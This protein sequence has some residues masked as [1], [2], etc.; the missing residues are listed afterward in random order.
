M[1]LARELERK[2]QR[3]AIGRGNHMPGKTLT[4]YITL[5]PCE[6]GTEKPC[7]LHKHRED[8]RPTLSSGMEKHII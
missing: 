8:I 7:L 1:L 3:R 2:S 5:S 6:D 4:A